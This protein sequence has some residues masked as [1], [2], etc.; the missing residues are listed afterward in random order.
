M[1]DVTGGIVLELWDVLDQ[2]GNKT[3]KTI[4][5]GE[6]FNP[7]E[8]HLVVFAFLKNLKG[9]FLI[10]KRAPTKM[11][12]NHWE[13]PAG[14][15]LSGETSL[16]AIIRETK[17]EVGIDLNPENGRLV[18]TLRHD[19]P[20]PQFADLWLF[21]QEINESQIVCDPEEVTEARFVKPDQIK[22]FVMI[23]KLVEYWEVVN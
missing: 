14:S 1:I 18:K 22:D 4:R 20:W 11:F 9:E 8:Y 3:G 16:E 7:G 12:P 2:N 21:E 10:S 17:E 6:P 19:P 15:A 23:D 5:R 13:F